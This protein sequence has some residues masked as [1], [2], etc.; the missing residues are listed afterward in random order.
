MESELSHRIC[1]SLA[2]A[3]QNAERAIASPCKSQSAF[4]M[5]E[6]NPPLHGEEEEWRNRESGESSESWRVGGVEEKNRAA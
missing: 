2:S 4:R 3:D 1:P 5:A 6:G